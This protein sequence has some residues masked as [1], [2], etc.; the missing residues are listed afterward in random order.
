LVGSNIELKLPITLPE[1]IHGAKVD[2]PTAKGTVTVTIPP[3]SSS[4][5]RLR[6]KGQGFTIANG[7][8][9]DML[10]ELH[11]KLPDVISPSTRDAL[12][13]LASGYP[14]GF[15]DSIHW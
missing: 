10:V 3:M 4:G 1:A 13:S 14:S 9:G 11:I 8:P 15:R 7:T 2:V 12:D 5:K 6:I